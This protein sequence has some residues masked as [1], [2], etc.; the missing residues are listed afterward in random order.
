LHGIDST[1]RFIFQ[2]LKMDYIK[3]RFGDDFAKLGSEIEKSIEHMFHSIN[4]IFNI[5]ER[6]WK[7]SIDMYEA[8]EEVVVL[9][10]LPGV[11][12]ESLEIVINSKA[13]RIYGARSE[14]PRSDDVRFSLAEIQYGSFER[15][16]IFPAQIDP[17]VASASLSSGILHIRLAKA[18]L[19]RTYKV[20]IE[21]G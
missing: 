21:G 11:E 3:I 19:N 13:I 9:A 2:E 14:V 17:E 18:K 5:A 8:P 20:P 15:I 16:L 6:S 10:E 7:P 4:P 1:T 12:E